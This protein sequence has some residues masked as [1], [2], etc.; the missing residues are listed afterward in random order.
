M[1]GLFRSPAEWRSALLALPD[2]AY[3]DLMRSIFG[4]IKTPFSKQRLMDDLSALLSREDTRQ[5]IAAY[6]NEKDRQ[7]I[8]AV[9]L[10]NEP[11]PGEIDKFFTGEMS[12]GELHGILLN[13]EERFI[14]YR[15][16]DEKSFFHLAL[17][18][19][20][21]PVLSSCIADPKILFPSFPLEKE[22]HH[23]DNRP[24]PFGDRNL[25]AFLAFVFEEPEFFRAGSGIRKRILDSGEIFFPG[26]L[27]S[28]LTAAFQALLILQR[29]GE[30][31]K[32]AESRLNAF[33]ALSPGERL[34]Y[35]A[36]GLY[37]STDAAAEEN[38]PDAYFRRN[39]IKNTAVILHRLLGQL[40]PDQ[41]YPQLTIKRMIGTGGREKNR[42]NADWL[43]RQEEIDIDR[44]IKS[45]EETGILINIPHHDDNAGIPCFALAPPSIV[46]KTTRDTELLA[47]DTPLSCILYPE[48]PFDYALSLARFCT[49]R[50]TGAVVRFEVTRSSV[51]RGFNRGTTAAAMTE[52]LSRLSGNRLDDNLSWTLKDWES[53]YAAVSLYEGVVLNLAE[54]RRYLAEAEPLA[55]MIRQTLAPGIYLLNIAESA[56]AEEALKKAGVDIVA[57]RDW[58]GN[59][60]GGLSVFPS[61]GGRIVPPNAASVPP[62]TAGTTPNAD[63]DILKEKFRSALGR[64]SIP[65]QEREELAARIDRRLIL[66]ESQLESASIRYEKLEARG[67][68]YVGKASIAKQ[69]IAS[70]SVIEVLWTEGGGK[71]GRT[72]GIPAALEKQGGEG[73]LVIKAL[74]GAQGDTQGDEA[75]EGRELRLPLGKISL[76]RRIKQ[77]IFEE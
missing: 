6:I 33:A 14:I 46:E 18:P 61:L 28:T 52:L 58:S 59:S 71:T 24:R 39:R 32:A 54:D 38:S 12:Y 75:A 43:G 21:E 64:L 1:K 5:I 16:R 76:L 13:L 20:L 35:F 7:V 73:V 31:L 77:S 68:D 19:V 45:L 26:G 47:M 29:E 42:D 70:K 3:F 41:C 15:F 4:N 2:H 40:A 53:R 8:T 74:P 50:E 60:E 69:A 57:R 34:E 66:F 63:V 49:L 37:L 44:L 55:S 48:I 62:N 22:I 65:K 23:D 51:V 56:A 25:A 67:L 11:T 9:A 10:L 30:H 17:N 36:A 27:F 72:M